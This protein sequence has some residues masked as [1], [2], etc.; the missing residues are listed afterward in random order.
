MWPNP[1]ETVDLATFTEE[2]LSGKLHF[3]FSAFYENLTPFV[4]QL[5]IVGQNSSSS[6]VQKLVSRKKMK[7]NWNEYFLG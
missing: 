6:S 1:Q 2:I 7:K 5:F 3:L 4:S